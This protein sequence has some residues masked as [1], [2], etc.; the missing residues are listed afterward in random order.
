VRLGDYLVP[1]HAFYDLVGAN[2]LPDLHIHFEVRDGRPEVVDFQITSKPDGR[3]IRSADV[4]ALNL[5][6]LATSVFQDFAQVVV[7][8]STGE[9]TYVEWLGDERA[10][11]QA[12]KAIEARLHAP[13]R[14]V[15][16]AA[17]LRRV[18]EVYGRHAESGSPRRAVQETLGYTSSRTAA[19][20]I[21]QARAAGFF[22][23]APPEPAPEPPA[24]EYDE[25]KRILRRNAG[26]DEED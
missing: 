25:L 26:R 15:A 9:V 14:G 18:A 8:D 19:R 23:E 7:D 12:R 13:G 6:D 17:E 16:T 20:R 3:G 22:D 10:T 21:Q 4:R 11:R 5:D 24:V 1:R 2:G